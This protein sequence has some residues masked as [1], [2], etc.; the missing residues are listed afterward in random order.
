MIETKH[1]IKQQKI[2]SIKETK[3]KENF[4]FELTLQ[5]INFHQSFP[6]AF[7]FLINLLLEMIN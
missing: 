7:H 3:K 1:T 5:T 4:W 2:T 6:L